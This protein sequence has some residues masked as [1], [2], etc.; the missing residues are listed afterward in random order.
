[1]K[2]YI[3][4]QIDDDFKYNPKIETILSCKE[5]TYAIEDHSLGNGKNFRVLRF[6]NNK[7]T[8]DFII[9][10]ETDICFENDKSQSC[11]LLFK[12]NDDLCS[13]FNGI[14]NNNQLYRSYERENQSYKV[15]GKII[16]T[17]EFKQLLNQ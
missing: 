14:I 8:H 7:R 2:K 10:S 16:S 11:M 6:K 12:S 4:G 1:M 13:L 9:V 5:S 3:K 17:I 15:S